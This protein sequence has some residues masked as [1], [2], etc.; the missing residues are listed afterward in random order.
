[1]SQSKYR[2]TVTKN[3]KIITL[4]GYS[5]FLLITLLPFLVFTKNLIDD[6]FSLVSILLVILL[7]FVILYNL[8]V[9]VKWEANTYIELSDEGIEYNSIG[10]KIKS[11]WDNIEKVTF[12]IMN[13]QL[14]LKK[15]SS[16]HMSWVMRFFHAT[17][18][19]SRNID[20]SIPLDIFG[21]SSRSGVFRAFVQEF[22]P[23]ALVDNQ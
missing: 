5:L 9:V 13:E 18:T 20:R 17:T 10:V 16:T 12:G 15:P 3:Q 1:M 2:Y 4:S 14:V 11:K 6:G 21:L 7:T 22:A 19:A 23:W 8:Y